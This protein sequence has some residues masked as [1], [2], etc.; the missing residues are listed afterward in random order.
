MQVHK[1]IK[2]TNRELFFD[3]FKHFKNNLSNLIGI[4]LPTL[5]KLGVEKYIT[6]IS[7]NYKSK[8]PDMR[9][10]GLIE[11]SKPSDYMFNFT[12]EAEF[13]INNAMLIQNSYNKN[14]LKSNRKNIDSLAPNEVFTCF[15]LQSNNPNSYRYEILQLILSYYDTTDMIRP[16]L[17]L[18]KFIK[19][20]TIER[21]EP[22][23]LKNILA[24]T[25]EQILLMQYNKDAFNCV[26][27]EIQEE[28]KRPIS[29]IYNF[30]QTALITDE[31]YNII[32][33]YGFMDRVEAEMNNFVV[34]QQT[35]NNSR[36]AKEQR[37]FRDNVLRA[38]DYKCAI[39]QKS[40]F[41][42]NRCLLEAAHIIPY[43]DGGSFSTNNG[44]A[45]SYEM[46]KMF[47]CGLFGFIYD[48]FNKVKIKI[49]QSKNIMDKQRIL[50]NMKDLSI[51]LPKDRECQ[52]DKLALEYNLQKY[53]L[54]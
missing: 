18:L 24:H 26:D 44:I 5:N 16:Y 11:Y 37:D 28:I 19:N 35:Q 15:D 36:P 31:N 1:K 7:A 46:H 54:K 14:N 51:S 3:S 38:Y 2:R 34:Y 6:L 12:Q 45:L 13:F 49:S 9:K 10:I 20:H 8:Y 47:D 43:R 30:L 42:N 4:E 22:N 53:L 27:K 21:L 41:I 29:Y 48:D 32:I 52:P 17:A 40:I 39:T 23:L 50:Q 33:D 25:K